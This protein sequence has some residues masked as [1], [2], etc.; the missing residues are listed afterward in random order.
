MSAPQTDEAGIRQTIR[1]LRAAGWE[2]E[3]VDD[4]EDETLVSN[5]DKA[6]KAVTAVDDAILVVGKDSK[7]AWVRFVLGNAPDE[8]V[9][10]YTVNLSDALEPMFESW[11]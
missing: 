4:G 3:Y 7:R 1:A 11:S 8:V 10:D 2:L 6:V 9:C 5:E